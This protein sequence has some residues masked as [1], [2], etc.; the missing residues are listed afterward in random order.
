[1]EKL[2]P[3]TLSLPILKKWVNLNEH[4]IADYDWLNVEGI[5]L[6]EIEQ[7]EL[8]R[9]RLRLLN[10]RTLL[11]NEATIWARGIYPLLLLAEQG[12]IEAWAGVAMR[13]TYPQF[14]IEGIADGVLGK[15]VS[16][17]IEAPY[18][19]VIEAKRGLE[20]QNPVYQLY[21]QLLAAAHLNWENNSQEPQEIFGCYTIADSWSFIRAE[22]NGMIADRPTLQIESSRQY[23]EQYDAETIAKILK[24]MVS[25]YVNPSSNLS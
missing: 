3:S 23:A 1:M 14:E 24:G 8:Q 21:G 16:G 18:L 22:V 20:A 12:N 19:I 6:S 4:G 2:I 7:Q 15:C 5:S 9:L 10:H 17:F 25:K 11:M 13:A